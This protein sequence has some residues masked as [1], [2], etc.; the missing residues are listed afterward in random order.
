M[1]APCLKDKGLACTDP[2]TTKLVFIECRL[3]TG[4]CQKHAWYVTSFI[5]PV[6]QL[7]FII[8]HSSV[9]DLI[10]ALL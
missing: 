4:H 10:I 6:R 8:P 5:L 1:S 9:R 2:A 7:L 3:G